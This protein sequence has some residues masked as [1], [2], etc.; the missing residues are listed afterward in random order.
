M[1]LKY[2]Y[3]R[4]RNADIVRHS[5]IDM[6]QTKVKYMASEWLGLDEFGKKTMG[7]WNLYAVPC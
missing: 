7:H 3:T 2:I 4:F 5:F 1:C 6:M